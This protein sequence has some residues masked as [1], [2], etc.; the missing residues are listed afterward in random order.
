M[1]GKKYIVV[2]LIV[3]IEHVLVAV[4]S[5][6]FHFISDVPSN[7]AIAVKKREYETEQAWID[8]R[9]SKKSNAH[10]ETSGEKE[11]E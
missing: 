8:L 4:V 2:L 9:K 5:G 10:L 3:I 7:V 11:E 6:I 1:T